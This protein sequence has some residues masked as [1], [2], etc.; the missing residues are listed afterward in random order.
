M[1][2]RYIRLGT[3]VDATKPITSV[4]PQDRVLTPIMNAGLFVHCVLAYQINLNVWSDVV[5]HLIR[6]L[7]KW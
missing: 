1:M 3:G 7:T 5:L 4:V 6:P 2:C